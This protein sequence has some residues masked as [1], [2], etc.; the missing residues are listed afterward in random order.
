MK[1]I[2]I[3]NHYAEPP[4]GGK[5]LRHYIFAKKL[6]QRGYD[7]TIFTASTIH[8]TKINHTD[9][10]SPYQT[11]VVDDVPFVF[12]KTRN[13]FGNNGG[14]V[15]NML[16]FYF[17]VRSVTRDFDCPD[18]IYT[19]GPHPLAWMAARKAAKRCNAKYIVETRDLWP[20]TFIA[21]GR[22]GKRHPISQVL[23]RIEKSIY[24]DADRLIFTFPGGAEYVKSIGLDPSK[25]R[26][27]NN[28]IDFEDFRRLV[29]EVQY[30]DERF[31]DFKGFKAVFT[32]AIGRANAVDQ[33]V[34][35][36][37]L[38]QDKE[39]SIRFY[40][41]GYGTE[42]EALKAYVEQQGIRN[43]I[44]MG[45]VKKDQIPSILEQADLNI[46]T[47]DHLPGVFR[48]G[49][50]PNKLFEYFASGNPTISNVECGYDLLEQYGSGK[51]VEGDPEHLAEG[52]LTFSRLT[53]EEKA[54]YRE[55][56]FSAAHAFDFETL[57]DQLVEVIEK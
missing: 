17:G 32:G 12:I 5:Y 51:T 16:D 39:E 13:Y 10:H 37:Q 46:L 1:K 18:V 25:V 52:I 50:S 2:W 57:T 33:I 31:S 6:I 34:K 41:F 49:L 42:E 48:Y 20:E 36:A 29:H 21:M 47:L 15:G 23:Y 43:V 26:Y 53:E 24:R 45:R 3:I 35:A 14:R 56:A 30:Y 55:K 19:S 54:A 9:G 4:D 44:F 38:I 7:V 22:F 28:G 27:V 8:N 40:I 11:Q